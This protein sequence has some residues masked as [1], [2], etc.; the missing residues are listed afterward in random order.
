MYLVYITDQIH[1]LLKESKK[2]I[3]SYKKDQRNNDLLHN[4]ILL[5]I[6]TLVGVRGGYGEGVSDFTSRFH[7]AG[8]VSR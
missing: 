6:S 2:S 3:V 5:N 8:S 7:F 4:I 1:Q